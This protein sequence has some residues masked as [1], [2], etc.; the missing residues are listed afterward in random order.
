MVYAGGMDGEIGTDAEAKRLVA[1]ALAGQLTDEEAEV[2]A[3]LGHG[4]LSLVLLAASKRIAEMICQGLS[5]STTACRFVTVRFGNVLGSNGSV[6]PIFRDQIR[7]GGPVTVTHPQMQRYFM[8][9]PEATQL[10]LQAATRGESGEVFVLDMGQ[11]VK[12]VD[13]ARDMI[14]LSGL[15]P[16]TDIEIVFTGIRPGEK[17]FEELS[18][19]E[20]SISKTDHDKIYIGKVSHLELDLLEREVPTFLSLIDKGTASEV[21]TQ[22]KHL[23]P[24]YSF[25]PPHISDQE[26][27]QEQ[28]IITFSRP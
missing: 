16:D 1:A 26:S 7:K 17:L 3:G 22:L 18:Q 9:I 15:V 2:L 5:L 8:T 28:K 27:E 12:I 20:E 24:E 13:L 19:D 11:P 4:L 21:K 23:V 25:V 10:V 14:R 6:F